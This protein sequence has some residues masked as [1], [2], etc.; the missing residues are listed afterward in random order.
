MS[1]RRT[2]RVAARW[3]VLSAFAAGGAGR[4]RAQDV[5]GAHQASSRVLRLEDALRIA[6]ERQPALRKVRAEHD[7]AEARL[8]AARAPLLPQLTGT[9]SYQRTT[10]NF[11]PRPGQVP[12]TV[13]GA[14]GS[15]ASPNRDP[16]TLYNFFNFGI[17]AS[18]LIY[19]FG[20]SSGSYQANRE[21]LRAQE[22]ESE[23]TSQDV[24]AQVSMAFLQARAYQELVAVARENLANTERHR[25]QAQSFVSAGAR[26]E[27][28]LVQ[29]RADV[30][31]ARVK[32][33]E[34]ENAYAIAIAAL[35]QAMGRDD[36]EAYEL[37]EESVPPVPS[38]EQ[39][40]SELYATALRARPDLAVFEH[41]AR[42]QRLT[43]RANK[44]GYGPALSASTSLTSGG[45]QL[46]AL[47]TNWN[48]GV[49][50]VWPLFQGG[51][52]HARVLESRA[53]HES[54][55]ADQDAARLA[56]RFELEQARL[57]V[58]AAKAVEQAAQEVQVNAEER[59][60][61]AEKRYAAG[62]GNAIEL[63][64]ARV[65]LATSQAQRVQ[66]TYSLG[67]A[68]VSLRKALGDLP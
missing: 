14:T 12:R 6:R 29:A 4:S 3:L 46:D 38:E 10:G 13:P 47:V 40:S 32:L 23:A 19:D 50:L 49:L 20:A 60:R 21:L 18:Q 56:A 41:R 24:T 54:L 51:A 48:A 39:A 61:M 57:G 15:N 67:A 1:A 7:Q 62:V 22:S 66:A 17:T 45:T 28:D 9:A 5:P 34:A 55:L 64:D 52:S 31:N 8:I 53:V 63:G 25:D 37:S 16:Y 43:I 11:V 58:R 35:E 26:P 65:A 44:G 33:I 27:I 36:A 68:R 42:A 2:L 59:L 30:A